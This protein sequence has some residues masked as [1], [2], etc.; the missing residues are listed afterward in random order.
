MHT[1]AGL[2]RQKSENV[3]NPLRFKCFLVGAAEQERPAPLEASR[4]RNY[5]CMV[6]G[7]GWFETK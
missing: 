1:R 3:E 7:F 5:Y 4:L 6:L 2:G